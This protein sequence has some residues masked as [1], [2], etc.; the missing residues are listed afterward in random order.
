MLTGKREKLLAVL[1]IGAVVDVMITHDPDSFLKPDI[2]P[3]AAAKV[4]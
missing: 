2:F 1:I 3:S 4:A